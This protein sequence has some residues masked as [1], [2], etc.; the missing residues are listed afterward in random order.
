MVKRIAII[1]NA[2][3]GKTT[4]ARRLAEIYDLE[5]THVD[6][7]QFLAGFE[8]RPEEETR[9]ILNAKADEDAWVIDG[10]GD[11]NVI[12][13]RFRLADV[14][15]Y[16]DFPIWRHYWWV[17]KRQVKAYWKTR[18][19]LPEGCSE[20]GLS[21][22]RLVFK[23]MRYVHRELGPELIDLMEKWGV[24][25]KVVRVKSVVDWKRVYEGEI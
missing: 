20:R 12:E 24:S 19:E 13:H 14:I 25:D 16:I 8:R 6:G 15:V 10:Y 22:T 9:A 11:L 4:L 23:V 1:G 3:G 2:G 18:P 5:V 21:H 7:V 17:I